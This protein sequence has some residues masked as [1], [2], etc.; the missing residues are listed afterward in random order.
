MLFFVLACTLPAFVVS[1]ITTLI[2]RQRAESWG[3]VD[4]PNARKVH[5]VPMPV[6]GGIGIWAGVV[7]PLAGA[8]LL[9]VN[10][11]TRSW[12][13]GILPDDVAVHLPGFVERSKLLWVILGGGTALSVMGLLDDLWNL[14]WKPR[15]ALQ[16]MV[17]SG[18]VWA[19]VSATVFVPVPIVGKLISVLWLLVLINAFNFLDN[20]D[21]LSSGIALIGSVVFSVVMLSSV[22][23]PRWLVGGVLLILAGSLAGFLTFNKPPASIF[24]GDT[25]SYFIGLIMGSMTIVGTF[26]SNQSS[27]H[28][29]LAP[30]LVLAVPLYDFCSVI[31]IRLKEGRSPF[32][33]DKKH[34]S[35]RLVEIGIRPSRAVLTIHL[36]T[37]TTGL[38][39]LLLYEVQGWGPAMLITALVC[40]VLAIIAILETAGR[41]AAANQQSESGTNSDD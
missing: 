6:G 34:F 23:D 2:V 1:V 5:K 9:I 38:G 26:Y 13:A 20:M 41:T 40:C 3:L 36:A 32:H 33:A 21:G 28:V 22:G 30:L 8:Q 35:H 18:L 11:A 10:A 27:R 4:N 15:L 16:V 24:M 37:L 17:A 31:L 7:L 19:G 39:A 29:I 14:P 12:L 25:G